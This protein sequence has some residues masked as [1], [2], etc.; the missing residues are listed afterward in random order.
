MKKGKRFF[1]IFYG[2]S[3]GGKS[4]V[5]R[6]LIS[7]NK[8]IFRASQDKIKWLIPDYY[9]KDH[10]DIAYR[11]LVKLI[12]GAVLEGFSIVCEGKYASYEK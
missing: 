3:C 9:W 10:S 7:R 1:L 6:L 8:N 2:H 5:V 11:L 4:S 12:K